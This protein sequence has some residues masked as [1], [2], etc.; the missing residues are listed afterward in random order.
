M[1]A[2]SLSAGVI[3]LAAATDLRAQNPAETMTLSTLIE[4][5]ESSRPGDPS[6]EKSSAWHGAVRLFFGAKELD[7]DDWGP[8]E[9][10]GEFAILTNFGADDWAVDLALD[11]RFAASEEE[12][13]LGLDVTSS[14]WE[15][16]VGVRK[17]FDT[18]S[19][20][21]PFMGAGLAFG[22]AMMDIEIDDESDAGIGV[23][24]DVGVDFSLGGPISLGLELSYSTIPIDIVGV[25]TDAGGLRFGFTVGFSW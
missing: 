15:L 21:M 24:F 18:G 1:K 9:S 10:Q 11:L 2:I 12:S 6:P 5:Q 16:N 20:V 23:W 13:V 17:V 22:G 7:E 14:S 8:V 25:D 3:L 4:N 19:I